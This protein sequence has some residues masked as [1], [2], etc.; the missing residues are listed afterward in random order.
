MNI[1]KDA[2][3]AKGLTDGGLTPILA[4]QLQTLV[5]LYERIQ[6]YIHRLMATD[7]V[8]KFCKTDRV[9]IHGS[10]IVWRS[11]QFLNVMKN[12]FDY[13]DKHWDEASD[14][15]LALREEGSPTRAYIT[16]SQVSISMSS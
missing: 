13:N 8:P 3:V 7:S 11:R 15:R 4:S 9:S 10:L 6:T 1:E 14:Q 16:I 2:M 12:V 5:K